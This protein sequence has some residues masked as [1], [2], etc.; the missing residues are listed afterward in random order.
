MNPIKIKVKTVWQGQVAIRDRYIEQAKNEERDIL[1]S[2]RKG[3]MLIP[4]NEIDSLILHRSKQPFYDK[5]KNEYHHLYY[6]KYKEENEQ[7]AQLF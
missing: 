2:L 1:I 4:F 6:F 3:R 7:Q 5:Y